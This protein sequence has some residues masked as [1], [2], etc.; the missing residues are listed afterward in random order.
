MNNITTSIY[1][2]AFITIIYYFI[3]YLGLKIFDFSKTNFFIGRLSKCLI[4][5]SAFLI[6]IVLIGF[7][8]WYLFEKQFYIKP[9][10]EPQIK[11]E[12][13]LR[14]VI[15]IFYITFIPTIL[16]L[17]GFLLKIIEGQKKEI[18]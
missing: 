13:E 9:H 5:G 7:I 17:L 3:I 18:D 8:Y 11:F 12:L 2:L 10:K 4:N 6:A 16:L 14:R 1:D 15:I